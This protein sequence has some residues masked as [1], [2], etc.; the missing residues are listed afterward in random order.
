MRFIIGIIVAVGLIVLLVVLLFGRG[1][2]PAPNATKQM[3]SYAVTSTVVQYT[4]D[5]PVTAD[6]THVVV[7]TT[8]GRDQTTLDVE[9]GYQ[10]TVIRTKSYANNPTAYAYFLRALQAAGFTNGKSDTNLR[11]ERG[12]CPLGHRYIYTIRDGNNISQRFW[13]TSCGNL[14]SFK[15]NAST[16]RELFQR[17]VPDYNVLTSG[18][19]NISSI[20]Q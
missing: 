20:P 3:V 6:Q 4:D 13:S 14:G 1:P 16:V 10:G 7:E 5:Y 15:G 17:Q 11:D 2:A 8:V 19:S 18:L 12:V 9:R